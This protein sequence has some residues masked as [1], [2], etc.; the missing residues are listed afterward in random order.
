MNN[1][2]H[3]FYERLGFEVIEEF[4]AYKHMEWKSDPATAA[5]PSAT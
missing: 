5:G 2:A 3:R 1:D 4:G